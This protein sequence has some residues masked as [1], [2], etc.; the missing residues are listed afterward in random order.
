MIGVKHF[1]VVA[2]MLGGCTLYSGGDDGPIT[3]DAAVAGPDAATCE[4]GLP[5]CASLYCGVGAVPLDCPRSEDASV[6]YCPSP[7]PGWCF[8]R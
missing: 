1:L 8:N 3:P 2:L 4:P 7:T 5:S 6:C